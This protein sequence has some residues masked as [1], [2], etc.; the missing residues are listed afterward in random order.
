MHDLPRDP[1]RRGDQPR[2]L[3]RP[4]RE[5]GRPGGRHQLRDPHQPAAPRP[6]RAAR[7][8]SGFAIPID[9]AL[10]IVEQL[11]DG[12]TPTH[13]RLGVS[14]P[15]RDQRQRLPTGA[16]AS[17]RSR[18]AARPTTPGLQ[19]G[20]VI[21]KVDDQPDRPAPT[22][23]SPRSAAYRPGD[24]VTLT[25]IARTARPPRP[26]T[27]DA[28]SATLASQRRPPRAASAA[29]CE[30]TAA[31]PEPTAGPRRVWR[32][33]HGRKPLAAFH[34]VS[35]YSSSHVRPHGDAAAGAE[36]ASGPSPT[37]DQGAD[38][39]AEVGPAVGGEP[40]E[41]AGVRPRAEWPRPRR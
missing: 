23:W 26:L 34:A 3:R 29:P 28:R 14:V 6:S 19:V 2:Q 13:A 17:S 24:K 9:E 7:S 12:E 27:A 32:A 15:T 10:P 21:T 25:V 16:A 4:A 36:R 5:H 11:R 40:A 41:R 8:A 38:H 1:D 37:C 33:Q 30:A 20:D 18:T 31:Y 22:R 35:A 39:D